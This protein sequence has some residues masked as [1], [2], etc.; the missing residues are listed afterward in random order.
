MTVQMAAP[1]GIYG[2]DLLYYVFSPHGV[3]DGIW[4]W[5][6]SVSSW[7]FLYLLLHDCF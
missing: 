3:F 5:V 1:D 4:D 2:G 6:A 7:E